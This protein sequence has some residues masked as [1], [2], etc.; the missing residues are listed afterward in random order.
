NIITHPSAPRHR[1]LAELLAK[2][3]VAE[4][5]GVGV[6]RMVRD[7]LRVGRARPAIE[8][9]ASP[10]VR[11]ALV[12]GAPDASWMAF[13][14][15]LRPGTAGSAAAAGREL[16]TPPRPGQHDGGLRPGGHRG[17]PRRRAA[18]D[19]G[20]AGPAGPGTREQDRAR[21]L[22]RAHAGRAGRAVEPAVAMQTFK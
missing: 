16:G 10:M 13:L 20:G 12:G 11:T 9:I 5:E 6:D 18:Q 19:A 15:E 4:R 21:V 8:E 2:L 7:M 22:L 17:Q 14:D 1:A 3:R